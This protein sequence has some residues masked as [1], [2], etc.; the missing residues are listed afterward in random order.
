MEGDFVPLDPDVPFQF[1]CGPQVPCFNQCC[2]DL[3]QVLSPY[4]IYRLKRRLKMTSSDFLARYGCEHTGPQT[5]LPVVSLKAQTGKEHLCPFV[6]GAGCQ[7]Y[8]DR[9]ASCRIY[10]LARAVVW[11]GVRDRLDEHFALLRE[12]HCR[13]F[14]QTKRQTARQWIVAQ[15]AVEYNYFNDLLMTI[16]S[17]K[18]RQRLGPLTLRERQCF[19]MALYDLDGFRAYLQSRAPASERPPVEVLD[20][21]LALLRFGHHWLEQTLFAAR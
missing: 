15:E 8:S 5:G 10:P 6:T 14:A 12:P 21:D 17:L 13:G 9:P 2:R 1:A 16:I 20:D 18:N 4:D 11:R 7:V 19:R 3:N